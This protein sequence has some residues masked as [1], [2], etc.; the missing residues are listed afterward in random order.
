MTPLRVVLALAGLTLGCAG[1]KGASGT[2]TVTTA[3]GAQVTVVAG[4]GTECISSSEWIALPGSNLECNSL[5]AAQV[6][7]SVTMSVPCRVKGQPATVVTIQFPIPTGQPAP[8]APT[9]Q[10]NEG[11]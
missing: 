9:V 5:C 1:L 4:S 6:P 11:R 7:G 2:A 10:P 8:A 3:S